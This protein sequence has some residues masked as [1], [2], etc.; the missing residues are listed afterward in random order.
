MFV[1]PR[2]TV[3]FVFMLFQSDNAGQFWYGDDIEPKPLCTKTPRV[4]MGKNVYL[5]FTKSGNLTDLISAM[6]VLKNYV[7]FL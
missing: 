6:I 1:R 7:N 5:I 3:G 4:E 2:G